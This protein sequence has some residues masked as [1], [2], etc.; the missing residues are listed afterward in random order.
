ME[1]APSVAFLP[2]MKDRAGGRRRDL[3]LSGPLALLSVVL[4]PSGAMS[5]LSASF[6]PRT[7]HLGP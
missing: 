3:P 1:T 4:A 7:C 2:L 6:P 5:C